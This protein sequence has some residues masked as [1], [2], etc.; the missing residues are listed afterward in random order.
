MSEC[1]LLKTR[2]CRVFKTR[3]SAIRSF[4][5][6]AWKSPAILILGTL[7]VLGEDGSKKEKWVSLFNGKDLEGWKV[8]IK[9]YDLGDNF[10]KT[11]RVEDGIL[12]VAYDQ[13]SK[14]DGKFGHIF[15][16]DKFSSYILGQ[17]PRAQQGP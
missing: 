1:H 11:F 9:G 15:Y 3:G 7:C 12:K 16:K 14:F 4:R 6:I 17:T 5:R 2:E 10:G 13:Y 8:K